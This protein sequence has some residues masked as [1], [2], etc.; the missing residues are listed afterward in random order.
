MENCELKILRTYTK[1]NVLPRISPAIQRSSLIVI[2]V[3]LCPPHVSFEYLLGEPLFRISHSK[4]SEKRRRPNRLIWEDLSRMFP[5]DDKDRWLNYGLTSGAFIFG[6]RKLFFS[7]SVQR[8]QMTSLEGSSSLKKIIE[9]IFRSER[10]EEWKI[11]N[12]G[13]HQTCCICLTQILTL[14]LFSPTAVIY[15]SAKVSR[16]WW[17]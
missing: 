9:S 4:W 13:I 14:N 11:T 7:S 16:S 3:V 2:V 5:D 1:I 17:V 6:I 15:H 10:K 12:H 8:N